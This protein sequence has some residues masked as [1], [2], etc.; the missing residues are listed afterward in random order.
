LTHQQI[1][2]SKK[3][4]SFTSLGQAP[5]DP[6]CGSAHQSNK[7]KGKQTQIELRQLKKNQ[8]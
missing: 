1:T 2:L 5:F 3:N 4:I 8:K 6:P 7:I